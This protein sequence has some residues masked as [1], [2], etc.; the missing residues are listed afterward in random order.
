[1]NPALP[2]SP[3]FLRGQRCRRSGVRW[4]S[5]RWYWILHVENHCPIWLENRNHFNLSVELIKYVP[6]AKFPDTWDKDDFKPLNV[7]R[8]SCK[9]QTVQAKGDLYTQGIWSLLWLPHYFS[10]VYSCLS[11][12][13]NWERWELIERKIENFSGQ[14][15]GFLWEPKAGRLC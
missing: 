14:G 10:Y 4:T 1:L 13:R 2:W 12:S 15:G 8:Q 6:T 9:R 7:H 3:R 5:H 11:M